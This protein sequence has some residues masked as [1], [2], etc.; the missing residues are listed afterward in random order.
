M[1]IS[2]TQT[3]DDM[4]TSTWAYRKTEAEEQAFYKT[5]FAFWMK[6]AKRVE[7][8]MGHSRIE[9]PLEYGSNDTLRWIGKGG[10]VPINDPQL[11]TM[12]YEDWKYVA[13]SIVRYGV[14]DQKNRGEAQ[15][16]NY[17]KTKLGAAERALWEEFERA[18]FS[19]G[20]G[21]GE[22]NGLQNIVA[23]LPTT[24]TLHGIDRATYTW[25]R[26]QY[27]TSTGAASVYLVSD[28]RNL[29]NTCS[30]YSKA[31]L[32]D[33]AIVTDQTS[34]EL[35]EDETMEQKRIV[36]QK[37]ADAG[38]ES[39]Q[40]KGRPMFYSPFAPSGKM[41]FINSNYLKLV[42]DSA[43]FMQMTEWKAIPEQVNDRVAQILCVL[44]IVSSRPCVHGVLHSIAA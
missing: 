30:N 36:N 27:K 31:E 39:V 34:F 40:F 15:L 10:T 28:M 9:I 42:K 44:N 23:D 2:W 8:I 22:C 7:G 5:P 19:D 1:S 29:M 4:F 25:F 16:I 37:M 3:V 41:Y 33:M 13:V 6:E 21:D 14:D 32:N 35:Y 11:L 26:N 24:G 38:F 18:F 17:V 43:Y 12:A 20:T